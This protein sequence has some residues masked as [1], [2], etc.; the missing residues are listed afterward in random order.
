MRQNNIFRL[1]PHDLRCIDK[2][3]M[4][5]DQHF[6]EKIS[7]DQLSLEVGLSKGKLQA[8]ILLKMKLTLH[9]YILKIRVEKAKLLLIDTNN[10]VKSIADTTGFINDSHFCKVFRKFTSVSPIKYRLDEAV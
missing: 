5:I 9:E 2:A 6:M 4:Y 3:I 1:T 8:G 10:P 7:A